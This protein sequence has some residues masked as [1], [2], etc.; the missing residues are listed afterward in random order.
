MTTDPTTTRRNVLRYG[1][2]GAAGAVFLAAC[3]S[4]RAPAGISG[5]PVP[6]TIVVPTVPALAPNEADKAADQAQLHTLISIESL[7]AEM[8]RTYGGKV[9]DAELAPLVTGFAA[10]HTANASAVAQLTDSKKVDEPNKKLKELFVDPLEATLTSQT[11][12]L[13][14]FHN[15]ESSLTATYINAMQDL[16]E[17]AT[18]QAVMAFG[19][20]SAR[21]VSLLGNGGSG[22]LPTGAVYPSSDLIPTAA[23]L[24]PETEN[25]DGDGETPES[26]DGP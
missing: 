10:D 26:T 21:R 4:D 9:T 14:F 5:E 12:V 24:A 20:A 11:A 7:V 22:E 15:L 13:S 23:F 25:A 6:T 2:L 8:Y 1:T 17:P 16:I 18:R 3:G 19:G